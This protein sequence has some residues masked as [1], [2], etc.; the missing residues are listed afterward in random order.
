K[1]IESFKLG[2]EFVRNKIRIKNLKYLPF[3]TLLVPLAYFHYKR[4]NP[5][6]SQV[7]L[8]QA[9]FWKAC[10]SNRYGSSVESKIEEDCE[11][12]DQ[13]LDDQVPEFQFQ[14]D[15]DTFKTRLIAQDYNLRNAF[16]KTILALYSYSDPKSLK[17]G[18]DID[19]KTVF[20]GYYKHN[21]HHFFPRKYLEKVFDSE[22]Y[23]RESIVN[24]AFAPADV[25]VEMRDIAPSE[26]IAQFEKENP[27]LKSILKSHLVDDVHKFGVTDN[28]FSMFLEKRAEKIENEFRVLLG[29]RTKTEEQFE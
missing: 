25:N 1:I 22:R 7:E 19:T 15:W 8:L 5:S 9:W 26:Y 2:L 28:N 29:L 6:N 18:R 10:L 23:R 21:L 12:F 16:C 3:D 17:D 4:H 11:A 14:I 20:S 13:I 24:I 27:H